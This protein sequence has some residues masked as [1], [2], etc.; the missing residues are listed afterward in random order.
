MGGNLFL[1]GYHHPN[2]HIQTETVQTDVG[3]TWLSFGS[4]PP[5]PLPRL[6]PVGDAV[7]QE[8]RV[9][10]DT[11]ASDSLRLQSVHERNKGMTA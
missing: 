7:Y 4:L 1:G 10:V 3:T 6:D 9:G 2:T 5:L 11:E 8:L